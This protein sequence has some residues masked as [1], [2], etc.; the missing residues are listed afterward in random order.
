MLWVWAI[1]WNCFLGG[2]VRPHFPSLNNLAKET[3]RMKMEFTY[4]GLQEQFIFQEPLEY[5]PNMKDVFLEVM[6]KG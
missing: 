4:F 5:L 2:G 3:Y 6:G 1:T